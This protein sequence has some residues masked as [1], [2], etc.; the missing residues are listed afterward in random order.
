[1]SFL[2]YRHFKAF[3]LA[4]VLVT[5]AVIGVIGALTIPGLVQSYQEKQFKSALKKFY[6]DFAQVHMMVVADHNGSIKGVFPNAWHMINDN[7]AKYFKYT[8]RC[9]SGSSQGCWHKEGE[10]HYLNGIEG[11]VSAQPGF[12][13]NNGMLVYIY[14]ANLTNCVA[15]Y[16]NDLCGY[17]YIDVNGFKGPN[18]V[19]RDIFLIGFRKSDIIPLG[20]PGGYDCD[21]DGDNKY[22]T[23]GCAYKVLMGEDY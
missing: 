13:L 4:E 17:F 2:K 16:F 8:K 11:E 7:Y 19:G 15:G 22:K 21:R 3:T 20:R 14:A 6:S 9:T 23:Y 1:M 18:I 12:I 10:W 5:L